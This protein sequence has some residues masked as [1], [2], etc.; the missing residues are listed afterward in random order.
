MS[1]QWKCHRES[2]PRYKFGENKRNNKIIVKT[3]S[4]IV[5]DFRGIGR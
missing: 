4:E 3:A 1:L 2:Y 5:K